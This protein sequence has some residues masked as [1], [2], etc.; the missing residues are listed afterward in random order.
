MQMVLS[1]RYALLYAPIRVCIITVLTL[2]MEP[3]RESLYVARTGDPYRQPSSGAERLC[4]IA[5]ERTVSTTTERVLSTAPER[6]VL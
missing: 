2:R 1:Q 6:L 5:I 3:P 4:A